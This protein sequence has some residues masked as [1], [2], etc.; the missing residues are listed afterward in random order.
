MSARPQVRSPV[1]TTTVTTKITADE[2]ALLERVA[3]LRGITTSSVVREGLR[4]FLAVA[5]F[6]LPAEVDG[7]PAGSD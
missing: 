5:T 1:R 7:E 6:E 3:K 4:M 2:H